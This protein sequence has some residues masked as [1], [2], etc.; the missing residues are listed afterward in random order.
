MPIIINQ[1]KTY[2]KRQFKHKSSTKKNS[3]RLT[4]KNRQFLQSLG[5]KT[6]L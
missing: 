6:L 5:F 4:H 3:G 1:L 2:K